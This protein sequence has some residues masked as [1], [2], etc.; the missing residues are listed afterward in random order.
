MTSVILI[1]QMAIDMFVSSAEEAFMKI[2]PA[3][4]KAHRE[5]YGLQNSDGIEEIKEEIKRD[6]APT[7]SVVEPTGKTQGAKG[8]CHQVKRW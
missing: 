1:L 5:E 2:L 3:T 6:R 8:I 4:K 7:L